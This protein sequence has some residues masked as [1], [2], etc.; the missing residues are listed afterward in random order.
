[1]NSRTL[2]PD[3]FRDETILRVTDK[4]ELRADEEFTAEFPR[5]FHTRIEAQLAN[6]EVI[7]VHSTNPKGHPGNPLTDQEIEQKFLEQASGVLPDARAKEALARLWDLD[8]L[9]D[10]SSLHEH[11]LV[12]EPGK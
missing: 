3:R 12:P 10:V 9:D 1:V 7:S 4:V 2:T 5:T 11:L 8:A 6:G